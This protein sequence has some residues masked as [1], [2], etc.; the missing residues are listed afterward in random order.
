MSASGRRSL[1]KN[2]L[3]SSRCA[4]LIGQLAQKI[5]CQQSQVS[6]WMRAFHSGQRK[7]SVV[8]MTLTTN[9]RQNNQCPFS[10]GIGEERFCIQVAV[11]TEKKNTKCSY[12]DLCALLGCSVSVTQP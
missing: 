12:D 1:R 8:R 2:M 3:I 4:L 7:V 9:V 5:Q 11:I 10:K 6:M